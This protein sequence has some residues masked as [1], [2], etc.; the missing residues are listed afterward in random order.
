MGNSNIKRGPARFRK[1][2]PMGA[3]VKGKGAKARGL[4]VPENISEQFEG[5]FFTCYCTDTSI[6]FES[7]T[8]PGVV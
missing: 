6:I 1:L 4:S 5:V 8:K 3:Y 7:G 2:I